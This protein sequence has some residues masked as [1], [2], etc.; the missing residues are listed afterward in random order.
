MAFRSWLRNLPDKGIKI[1]ILYDRAIEA[2]ARKHEIDEAADLLKDLNLSVANIANLEWEGTRVTKKQQLDSDDDDDPDP[3]AVLLSTNS[4]ASSKKIV[5][6]QEPANLIT[7]QDLEEIKNELHLDPVLEQM[8]KNE[9]LE[10]EARFLPYKNVKLR[11]QREHPKERDNTSAT[12]PVTKQVIKM[13]TLRESLETENANRMVLKD[14]SEKHTAERLA[15]KMKEL[16]AVGLDI[17]N[18]SKPLS[19]SMTKYRLPCEENESE[20]SDESF[21]SALS[22]EFEE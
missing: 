11:E 22:D 2:L 12:P 5:K 21:E 13:L 10:P 7:E 1:Q 3:L 19:A 6:Q 20:A 8:C 9:K 4:I 18:L 15:I 17:S 14:V 16:K